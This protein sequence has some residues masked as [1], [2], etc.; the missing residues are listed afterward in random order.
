M[1][2]GGAMK[3][4]RKVKCIA[5]NERSQAEKGYVLCDSRL[6]ETLEKA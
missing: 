1:G 2:V 6:R 4:W 3:T 5:K